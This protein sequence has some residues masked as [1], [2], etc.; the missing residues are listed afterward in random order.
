MAFAKF[1]RTAALGCQAKHVILTRSASEGRTFGKI[2]PTPPSLALR[3]SM[4]SALHVEVYL[5]ETVTLIG[6]IV[7]DVHDLRCPRS[8]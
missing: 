6:D 7:G 4:D 1:C 8:L 3:V 2:S 5:T